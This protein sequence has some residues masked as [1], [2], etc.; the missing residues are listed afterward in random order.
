M[1]T[2]SISP[3]NYFGRAQRSGV[4]LIATI[5][6]KHYQKIEPS[7]CKSLSPSGRKRKNALDHFK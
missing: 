4:S 2:I 7:R 5:I 3:L 6:N 1:H